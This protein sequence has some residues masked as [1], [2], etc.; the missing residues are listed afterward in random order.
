[1]QWSPIQLR[2][3]NHQKIIPMGQLQGITMDI[4][5]ANALADFEVIDIID[6]NNPYLTILGIEWPL[7]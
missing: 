1:M 2:M 5:G 7:I 4:E 6:D 3:E